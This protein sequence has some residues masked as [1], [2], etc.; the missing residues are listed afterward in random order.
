MIIE[1]LATGDE[2]LEGLI[3]DTNT[4]EIARELK[5]LGLEVSRFN[6]VRDDLSH[7]IE[8]ITEISNRA[9]LC[10][11]TGGLG[12][13]SDDLTLDAIAQVLEVPLDVDEDIWLEVQEKFK[14]RNLA[15]PPSNIRQARVPKGAIP[16]SNGAGIAPGM[17]VQINR[18]LF[19]AFPGVPS[20]MTWQLHKHLLPWLE[21]KN[22]EKLHKKI[23][24]FALISESGLY[25]RINLLNLPVSVRIGYQAL[26][27]EHRVKLASTDLSLLNQ[28]ADQIKAVAPEHYTNDLDLPL[29]AHFVKI[30]L[31]HQITVATAE[32]CT[33]GG[34]SAAIASVS[35][36]SQVLLGGVVSYQN[37]VKHQVLG[38]SQSLLDE[39]GPFNHQC[40]LE[41]A[42]GV[43]KLFHANYHVAVSGIAGPS[44]GSPDMPVGS[45]YIGWDHQ[46]E[47]ET[48]Y[49]K[50]SGSREHIQKS[51][52]AYI[53]LK[54][55]QKISKSPIF[56]LS[57]D[58]KKG[59]THT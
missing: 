32:S 41:M 52:I 13:T 34:L 19:F 30:A 46:N 35:G 10:V 20:E 22:H 27:S 6:A 56:T 50:F 51:T 53:L 2:V 14:K 42:K 44:G 21:Q 5:F 31:D 59:T 33:A 3:V 4:S 15:I 45:M 48:E 1:I 58:D 16:L 7:I 37:T 38:V 40:V 57:R 23:L 18:C 49:V 28:V 43:A 25:D 39:K 54:L 36:A 9:D 55:S 17:Q 47:T 26:G 24:R 8:M 29:A 12:P 11:M